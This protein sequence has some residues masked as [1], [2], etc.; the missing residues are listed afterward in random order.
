MVVAAAT[1]IDSIY[2]AAEQD[3]INPKAVATLHD[4]LVVTLLGN[5]SPPDTIEWFVD[6]GNALN[7]IAVVTTFIQKNM[8]VPKIQRLREAQ[9]K[10]E[11]KR[12]KRAHE[13]EDG[14]PSPAHKSKVAAA[15]SASLGKHDGTAN[16]D[17]D[18]ETK[19]PKMLMTQKG[20]EAGYWQF[21]KDNFEPCPFDSWSEF[22]RVRVV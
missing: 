13:D 10:E 15:C 18:E 17:K 3:P 21:T 1:L 19:S 4:K 22:D 2:D 14:N 20:D 16:A 11:R 9:Q 5:R 6:E 8:V 7:H 12:K